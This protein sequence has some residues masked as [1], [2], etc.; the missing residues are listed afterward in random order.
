MLEGILL[1]G[2]YLQ[3]LSIINTVFGEESLAM[4]ED[5]L[6]NLIELQLSNLQKISRSCLTGVLE[7][8]DALATNLMKLK[9]TRINLNE[10]KMV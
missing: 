3:S 10:P 1:Q 6:P 4:L 7:A 2:C 8:V 9:L 5:I